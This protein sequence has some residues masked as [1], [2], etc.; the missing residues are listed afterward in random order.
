MPVGG[1]RVGILVG[2]WPALDTRAGIMLCFGPRHTGGCAEINLAL[3]TEP[4][5]WGLS[6]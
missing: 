4:E 5:H 1:D 6:I 2:V 3:K